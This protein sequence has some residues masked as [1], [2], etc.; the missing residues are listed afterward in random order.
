MTIALAVASLL[1]VDKVLPL[2]QRLAQGTKAVL[3]AHRRTPSTE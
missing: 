2:Q 1:S 3:I